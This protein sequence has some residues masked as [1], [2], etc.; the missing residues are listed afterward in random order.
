SPPLMTRSNLSFGPIAACTA[1]PSSADPARAK[2][3]AT[4]QRLE[5]FCMVSLPFGV[6]LAYHR[7]MFS[8]TLFA[9]LSCVLALQ[10]SAQAFPTKPI[11]LVVGYPPGGSGDF[12]T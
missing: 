12:T 8:R 3:P 4:K 2:L 1:R 6:R 9:L 5:W 10:A 11:R 7:A